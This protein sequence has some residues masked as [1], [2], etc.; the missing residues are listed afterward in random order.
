M[1]IF[2]EVSLADS[3]TVLNALFGF[4]AIIYVLLYGICPESFSLFYMAVL[5]DGADGLVANK[6]EKSPFG[7]ELDSLA[8]TISFG[9]FPAII[10]V[11]Y[12]QNLFP[13][14][15]LLVAFSILRLARFNVVNFRDF[16]G[17]PT[18]VNALI[19]TSLVR[20]S[21]NPVPLA[22]I[23]VILSV[24]MVSDVVYPRIRDPYTLLLVALVILSAIVFWEMTYA[25]VIMAVIYVLYPL[26]SW[27]I[28]WRGQHSK[29]E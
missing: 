20:F 18:V 22:A 4:S 7:R 19:V 24:L 5:A 15:A 2:K 9:V 6:T 23:M 13:F 25:I 14:A 10:A 16:Y 26:V 12:E 17:L 11:R 29:L 8:D 28:K 1:K 21:L 3:L 27:V